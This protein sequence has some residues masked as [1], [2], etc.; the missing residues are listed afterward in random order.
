MKSLSGKQFARLLEA[1]GWELA[2]IHGSHHIYRRPDRVERISVPI[3]GNRPLK[4]GL[5][6]HLMKIAG[7][8]ENEL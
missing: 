8:E 7:I 6:R 3:H 1:R 5:Q 4:L 2:R